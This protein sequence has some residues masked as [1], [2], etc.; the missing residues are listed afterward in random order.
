[1]A[2]I[3]TRTW[4]LPL[5]ALVGFAAV[6]WPVWQWLWFEWMSNDYYS[7]GLLILPV[8]I[9]LAVQ[10]VRNDQAFVYTPGQ[11]S[12]LSLIHI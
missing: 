2:R 4:W 11:G 12:G 8:A 5:L 9:F 3:P 6:T 1:M 10:R 7:H